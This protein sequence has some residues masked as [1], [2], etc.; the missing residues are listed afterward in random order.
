VCHKQ[1]LGLELFDLHLFVENKL[2][3]VWDFKL[4]IFKFLINELGCFFV[5][6]P[7]L[8]RFRIVVLFFFAVDRLSFSCFSA[9]AP[10]TLGP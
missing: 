7:T 4:Q 9:F 5:G 1:K 2:T 3:R 6:F 10:M 8:L